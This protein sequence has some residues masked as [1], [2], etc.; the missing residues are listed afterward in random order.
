[1]TRCCPTCGALTIPT[2]LILPRIKRRV[3]DIVTRNPGIS[4]ERLRDLVWDFDPAGGAACRHAIY[5]HIN[6]LNRK[7]R[8]YGIAVRAPRGGAGGYRLIAAD[9]LPANSR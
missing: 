8:P 3:L 9:V 2:G 4:A 7:L 1:M 5:V 6:Q